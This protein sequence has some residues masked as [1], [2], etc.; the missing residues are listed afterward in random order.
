MSGN[1]PSDFGHSSIS[2]VTHSF[3]KLT[4]FYRITLSVDI[5]FFKDHVLLS[6]GALSRFS[7]LFKDSK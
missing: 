5:E 4:L 7:G 6:D 2:I 1:K 3:T